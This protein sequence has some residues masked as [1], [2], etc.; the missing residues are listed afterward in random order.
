MA[1][2]NRR[3]A[4]RPQANNKGRIDR[5]IDGISRLLLVSL[6]VAAVY[7]INMLFQ[8]VNK[9][10]TEIVVV[11]ELSYL[12]QQELVDLVSTEIGGGRRQSQC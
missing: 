1:T 10:V 12:Q 5:F 9:P 11:G 4:N 7:G 6:S 2:Q 8:A 3:G